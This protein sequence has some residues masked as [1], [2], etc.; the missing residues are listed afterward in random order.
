MSRMKKNHL[1]QYNISLNSAYNVGKKSRF[2]YQLCCKDP[3]Y[4]TQSLNSSTRLSL[5]F[6]LRLK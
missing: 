2:L 3:N 4:R 1:A 6:N 5:T